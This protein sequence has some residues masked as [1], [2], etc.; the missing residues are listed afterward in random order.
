MNLKILKF[1]NLLLD[2]AVNSSS[3]AFFLSDRYK[4]MTPFFNKKHLVK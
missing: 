2:T 1:G 4:M 3:L